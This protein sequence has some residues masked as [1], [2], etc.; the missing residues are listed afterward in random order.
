MLTCKSPRKVMLV[1][2][3]LA[4]A[5]L[6]KYTCK[7]SRR[8]FTLPQLFACL[9][10]KE[11]LRRSYRGAEA[12]LRDAEPWCRAIGMT[13]TP[14]HNTLCRAAAFLL[15]R[16]KVGKLIDAV[17]RWAAV[18]RALGLN[19][20]PLAVDSTHL[21]THHVSRHY[22]RRCAAQR[23]RGRRGKTLRKIPANRRRSRTLKRLPKLAVAVTRRHS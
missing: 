17:A 1:A 6:P 15:G 18:H 13:K 20:K 14:D 5:V 19:V 10:V 4:A 2:H 12:L 11:V 8:D 16:C 23:Y 22:A 21:E 7:F 9:V 3:H